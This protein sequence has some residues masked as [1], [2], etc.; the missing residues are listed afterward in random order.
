M[1]RAPKRRPAWARP[2]RVVREGSEHLAWRPRS[3]A[4]R[5]IPEVSIDGSSELLLQVMARRRE[6]AFGG[7]ARQEQRAGDL[8]D[9]E[10]EPICEIEHRAL[11][12]REPA[13]RVSYFE[14][15][16]VRLHVLGRPEGRFAHAS[17]TLRA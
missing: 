7:A 15:E 11:P 6:G 16:M 1:G 2:V 4:A 9:G 3:G 17:T 10:I 5:G 12:Y 8:I 14:P 13:H